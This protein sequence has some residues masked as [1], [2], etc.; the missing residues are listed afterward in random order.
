MMIN[1]VLYFVLFLVY[2]IIV[3]HDYINIHVHDR[4]N[5][6]IL[7]LFYLHLYQESTYPFANCLPCHVV[8]LMM[9]MIILKKNKL[10]VND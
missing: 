7:P 6:S 1:L 10:I 2:I 8:K 4:L 3:V 5:K 9:M